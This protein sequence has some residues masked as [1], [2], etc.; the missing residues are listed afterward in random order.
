MVWCRLPSSTSSPASCG[1]AW[2][3]RRQAKINHR[4]RLQ[5][6]RA[7][8]KGEIGVRWKKDAKRGTCFWERED[9]RRDLTTSPKAALV[10]A[11]ETT[12]S[13]RKRSNHKNNEQCCAEKRRGNHRVAGAAAS[14]AAPFPQQ[15]GSS[16][17]RY[18]C[19]G[20]QALPP[21]PVTAA[22][23]TASAAVPAVSME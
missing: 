6:L 5:V 19:S 14:A 13:Y 16:S 4:V 12:P 11:T 10:C 9:L 23:A 15:P 20:G 7:W 22:A 21:V 18:C 17:F 8:S 1:G 3:Q 2:W